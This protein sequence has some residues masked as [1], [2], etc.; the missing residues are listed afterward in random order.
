MIPQATS[1]GAQQ[2]WAWMQGL[3]APFSSIRHNGVHFCAISNSEADG[4]DVVYAEFL[5]TFSFAGDLEPVHVPRF[6]V[7][8]IGKSAEGE[9]GF[10]GLQ[11][12]DVRLF[13][14]TGLLAGHL[15]KKDTI[16]ESRDILV[17]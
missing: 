4:T 14:D 6:F 13:W 15:K 11:I 12:R 7:F 10:A 17:A 1:T 9:A 5:T 2:I 8:T 16:Q 3:F